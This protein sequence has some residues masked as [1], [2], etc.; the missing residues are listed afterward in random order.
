MRQTTFARVLVA[1]ALSL[2]MAALGQAQPVPAFADLGLRLNLGDAVR[3]TDRDGV[4]HEGRVRA[5]PPDALVIEV[6]AGPRSFTVESTARVQRRGDPVWT[7]AA[8]GFFPGFFMGAQF[9]V[10][11][12]DHE[13]PLLTYVA[14]GAIVG[15]GG[16]GVGVLIDSLHRGMKDVYVTEPRR[17]ISVAPLVTG[18]RVGA[19]AAIRW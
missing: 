17:T 14:A 2:A 13:E 3:V 11:F 10:G 19:R 6:P 18:G 15:L 4:R 12:S 7:G 5:L 1:G 16:A 8:L 9:V